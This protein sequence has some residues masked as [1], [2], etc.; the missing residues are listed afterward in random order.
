[1]R[2]RNCREEKVEE[3]EE[4]KE[5]EEDDDDEEEEEEEEE[6]ADNNEDEDEENEQEGGPLP[7]LELDSRVMNRILRKVSCTPKNYSLSGWLYDLG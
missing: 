3:A 4:E 7:L 1:M 5:E 6:E 2:A